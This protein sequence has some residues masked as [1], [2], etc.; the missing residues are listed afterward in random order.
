M[1]MVVI[2]RNAV[3]FLFSWELMALSSYFLVTT[4]NERESVQRAGWT[5]LTATHL[6][7]TALF[8]LFIMMGQQAGSLDFD[9]IA[10]AGTALQPQATLFFV[11]ALIGFGTKAGI[12]PLHVWL[13]E[14]HPA[15]P[16]HIS[17]LMSGVMIKTGIYGVIRTLMWLPPPP[18]GWAVTLIVIGCASG[19]IGVLV[20]LAQHDLKRLLAYHSV[21]NIGIIFWGSVSGCWGKLLPLR[22]WWCWDLGAHCCIH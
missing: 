6:G 2:A 15:A 18:T 21:E 3:L 13:P 14:A 11:L 17:A 10:A 19:V 16:S 12:V 5:Y 22:H 20:A 9:R 7:T 1:V 8:F 4:D